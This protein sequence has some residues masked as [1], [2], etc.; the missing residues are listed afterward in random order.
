MVIVSTIE[1]RYCC[2]Q[3]NH[4]ERYKSL[5]K[6]YPRE[7]AYFL[8]NPLD[9]DRK[10]PCQLV[11]PPPMAQEDNCIVWKPGGAGRLPWRELRCGPRCPRSLVQVSAEVGLNTARKPAGLQ[12][13]EGGGRRSSSTAR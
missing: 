9:P 6:L 1:R 8:C 11:P 4:T 5:Q 13:H 12:L 10:S 3:G 2:S 7:Q